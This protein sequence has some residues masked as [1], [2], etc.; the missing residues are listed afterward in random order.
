MT[1][2]VTILSREL[3]ISP[4]E[5]TKRGTGSEYLFRQTKQVEG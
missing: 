1:R 2:V 3:G 5:V 4:L